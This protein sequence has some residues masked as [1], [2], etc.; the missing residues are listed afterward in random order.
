MLKVIAEDFINHDA[1]EIVLPLYREL[2]SLTRKEPLNISY[3]LFVDKED[4]GHFIFLESWPD[5]AALDIHCN[6]EHFQR[7]VPQIDLH[8]R[9]KDSYI[10]MNEVFPLAVEGQ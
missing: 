10:Q 6:T 4:P 8:Q 7:L 1:V 9:K 5:R 3:E 2:V